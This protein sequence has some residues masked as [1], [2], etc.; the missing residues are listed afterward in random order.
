[1]D[2]RCFLSLAFLVL[3]FARLTDPAFA[4]SVSPYQSAFASSYPTAGE[5][6]EKSAIDESLYS[7]MKWR[8]VGPFR[9]GRAL[10]VQ[11]V[12]GEPNVYYFGA[13]A[14]GVWKTTDG[15]QTWAPLFQKE[16]VSSIGDIGV[17]QSDHNV[18]YVGTGEAAIRGDITFGD[19]VYKSIDG[20]KNWKNIGLKDSRQIGALIVHPTNP[21]IVFVAALG[22][23]F[24]PNSERGISK[25]PMA[26]VPG[27]TS[28]SKT[29]T[30]AESISC[31]IRAIRAFF[32]P[33]FGKPDGSLGIFPAADRAADCTVQS[34]VAKPGNTLR[35]TAYRMESLDESESLFRA[36]IQI[37]CTRWSRPR[38]VAFSDQT[39]AAN[40]G[41][42][43]TMTD[44]FG[45]GPGIS[46]RSTRIRNRLIRSMS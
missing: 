23:A 12:A 43:S 39:T 20:G 10:A 37:G 7:G 32:S 18:I 14:G 35:A 8:L 11:G 38:K 25:R 29:K 46:A 13:V 27:G 2:I 4:G 6:P 34:M 41:R 42:E 26:A 9:G 15:G 1:M 33:R 3:L 19:G 45:N 16:A 40:T 22:H 28:C 17:A 31:S 5:P 24:G 30:Q 44:A 21:D 36:P